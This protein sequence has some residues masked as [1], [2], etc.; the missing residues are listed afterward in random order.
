[1]ASI[2]QQAVASKQLDTFL[3]KNEFFLLPDD[4]FR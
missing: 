2:K 1:M 4:L 3:G